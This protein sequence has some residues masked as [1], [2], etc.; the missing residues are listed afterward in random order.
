MFQTQTKSQ[1]LSL[2]LT[3]V[4]GDKISVIFGSMIEHS[5]LPFHCE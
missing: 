1:L 3:A 2:K 4:R 5:I